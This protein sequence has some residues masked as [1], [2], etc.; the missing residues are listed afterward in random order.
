MKQST[1]L[2]LR[3]NGGCIW[4]TSVYLDHFGEA[5]VGLRR[6]RPLMLREVV[7]TSSATHVSNQPQELVE[8]LRRRYICGKVFV[9]PSR[10]WVDGLASLQGA[11]LT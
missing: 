7:H 4:Q 11:L 5:D 3:P 9:A 1:V 6:G 10:L 8:E 2:I